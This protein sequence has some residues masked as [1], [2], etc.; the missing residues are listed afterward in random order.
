MSGFLGRWSRRKR[1]EEAPEPEAAPPAPRPAP[2]P[3]EPAFDPDSLPALDS[4]GAGSDLSA[5]LHPKV[6]ALLRQAA[7]RRVWAADPGIRDFMGPADYAW[8]FNA[9]DGVPGFALNLGGDVQKLLAQAIGEVTAPEREPEPAAPPLPEPD[10]VRMVE[11]AP[12][13]EVLEVEAAP[14]PPPVRAR[15]H[16]G[17]VPVVEVGQGGAAPL[18]PPLG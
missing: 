8:D 7:M 9:P 4:L 2:A 10:P 3:P 11:A 14:E 13:P 12:L 16:G 1:G 17:A 18:D 5:F 15:R 6:P